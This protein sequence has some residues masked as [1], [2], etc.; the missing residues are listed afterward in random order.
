MLDKQNRRCR[1]GMMEYYKIFYTLGHRTHEVYQCEGDGQ[2]SCKSC[3]KRGVHSRNWT[4]FFYAMTDGGDLLCSNCLDE[5]LIKQ[6]IKEAKPKIKNKRKPRR[7]ELDLLIRSKG[8]DPIS[9]A[10]ELGY[11]QGV[12][13]GWLNGHRT[14]RTY[15]LCSLA[16]ILNEPVEHIAKLIGGG[17][18]G[19]VQSTNN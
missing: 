15:D 8:Y 5:E 10:K 14:P 7:Y 2:S 4:S 6:R 18:Y 19:N 16:N 3:T 12:V 13:Y 9:L 17:R 11:T 1:G